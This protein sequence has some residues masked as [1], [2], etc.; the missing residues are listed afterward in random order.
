MRKHTHFKVIKSDARL[1]ARSSFR[2]GSHAIW[3]WIRIPLQI[4]EPS[5]FGNVVSLPLVVVV[6]N[7]SIVC[8]N[9]VLWNLVFSFIP[10]HLFC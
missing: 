5:H 2:I 4:D 10:S 8:K 9:Q 7:F 3:N 6:V 1:S